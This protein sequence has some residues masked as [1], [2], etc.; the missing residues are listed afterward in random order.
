MDWYFTYRFYDP[1]YP[2][3][4]QVMLK[5][6]NQ[7]KSLLARQEATKKSM[8]E[9]LDRL[10][11]EAYNPF[12]KATKEHLKAGLLS[13]RTPF[14]EALRMANEKVSV[15]DITKRDLSYLIVL[16]ERA[17]KAS[18]LQ[19]LSIME[20]SRRTIK[21]ILD[22]IST[23]PDRYNKYRSYLMILF[24]ELCELEAITNNPVRD[25]KK[26]KVTKHL[27]SVLDNDERKKVNDYL[28]TNYPTFHRFLHIFFHSG[29]RISELIR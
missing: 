10:V 2:K 5:G 20:I 29:A 12:S 17:V 23:T 22:G 1:R 14:V 26:K 28:Q 27:R 9:E 18:K 16:I 8:A 7:F 15:S 21:L 25:I 11:K 19:G 4:K 6:M 3:P 13:T 24:S